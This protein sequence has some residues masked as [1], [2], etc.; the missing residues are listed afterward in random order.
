MWKSTHK[1][2]A[3]ASG[4]NSWDNVRSINKVIVAMGTKT[5]I[6]SKGGG[7]LFKNATGSGSTLEA[8]CLPVYVGLTFTLNDTTI[9]GPTDDEVRNAISFVDFNTRQKSTLIDIL[10]SGA[11]TE[12]LQEYYEPQSSETLSVLS[13][14]G[15]DVYDHNL[16]FN[17]YAIGSA[18]EESQIALNI[19]FTL[20]DG[21]M[22][23]FW[24]GNSQTPQAY[25]PLNIV[26]QKK[27]SMV[28]VGSVDHG[29]ETID[30]NGATNFYYM[31]SIG[32]DSQDISYALIT[33]RINGIT[34]N[35]YRFNFYKFSEIQNLLNGGGYLPEN[36]KQSKEN[37][38]YNFSKQEFL[39]SYANRNNYGYLLTA[40]QFGKD[41]T[42][43]ASCAYNNGDSLTQCGD[44]MVGQ[45][46]NIN[47]GEFLCFHFSIAYRNTTDDYQDH[48]GPYNITFT[49]NYNNKIPAQLQFNGKVSLVMM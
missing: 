37:T 46:F 39:I 24:T 6:S 16:E 9:P 34:Y 14:S 3:V 20:G 44:V 41:S 49:D 7:T 30:D 40:I 5:E 27:Y 12:F 43:C 42:F 47:T 17:L 36:I 22:G 31:D 28:D 21:S 15:T 1:A 35:G 11:T 45:N 4:T 32:K 23:Y 10:P 8:H 38:T 25:L 48:G 2:K 19:A 26:P 33:F 13:D 29:I 18:G